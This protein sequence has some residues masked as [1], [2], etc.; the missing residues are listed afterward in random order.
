[1]TLRFEEDRDGEGRMPRKGKMENLRE[2]RTGPVVLQ[3]LLA[4]E[5]RSFRRASHIG[6]VSSE[7]ALVPFLTR[8]ILGLTESQNHECNARQASKDRQSG[9]AL[10]TAVDGV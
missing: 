1:M 3:R 7:A 6:R 8:L 2:Q 9:L 10:P 4:G 5:Q